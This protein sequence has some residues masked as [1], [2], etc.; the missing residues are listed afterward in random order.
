MSRIVIGQQDILLPS[1]YIRCAGRYKSV[2][3]VR[4]S[5]E[6]V[7]VKIKFFYCIFVLKYIVLTENVTLPSTSLTV[8][9]YYVDDAI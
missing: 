2:V 9:I 3:N 7:T 5:F 1:V 4:K 6:K 8:T